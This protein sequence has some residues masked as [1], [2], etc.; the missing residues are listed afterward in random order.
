M[1]TVKLQT[2]NGMIDGTASFNHTGNEKNKIMIEFNY[3]G[4][5]YKMPFSRKTGKLYAY[6]LPFSVN[7]I[8]DEVS[9]N[10]R[11]NS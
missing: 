9:K 1:N 7:L 4:K 11:L 3:M 5:S 2:E 8:I 6:K 10:Y